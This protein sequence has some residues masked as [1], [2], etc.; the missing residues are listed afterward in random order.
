M[1]IT[2]NEPYVY[3]VSG[4]DSGSKAMGRCSKWVN[5]LCVAGDSS[6]EPYLVSHNL[7][8]AH[9]AAVEEFRNCDKVQIYKTISHYISEL[10]KCRNTLNFV[11]SDNNRYIIFF[12]QNRFQKMLR[13]V[14]CYLL[15]GSNLMILIPK[16][17]KKQLNE[18]L[19]PMLVGKYFSHLQIYNKK[20][21]TLVCVRINRL[22]CFL[23]RHL[24]PLIFG[25]YPETMKKNAENR[26][27]SFTKE[28]SDMLKNSFDFVGINY[29]TAKFVAH[30]LH[31]DLSR[32]RFSTD[33]HLEYKGKNLK[34]LRVKKFQF[35]NLLC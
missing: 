13:L 10:E 24:D 21:F 19:P 2:F 28:Q 7:L 29:Y 9:A 12:L 20:K 17:I 35:P 32:L 25:D 5:S 1:W 6:T 11:F 22:T 4:Y 31:T 23:C 18:L 34:R 3:S 16:R 33:Q 27:P 8:L 26:L 30:K 15:C 14:Q